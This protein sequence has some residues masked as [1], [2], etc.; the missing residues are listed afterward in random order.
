MAVE[1][2]EHHDLPGASPMSGASVARVC[3]SDELTVGSGQDRGRGHDAVIAERPQPGQLALDPRAGVIARPVHPQDAAGAGRGIV[4][5]ERGV[6]RDSQR[7]EHGIARD[8]IVPQSG[9]GDFVEAG[10]YRIR[11]Q[12]GACSGGHGATLAGRPRFHGS[13]PCPVTQ[14]TGTG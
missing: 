7:C 12:L 1:E 5:P 13:H 2:F 11:G 3:D 9:L 10:P 4:H 6:L 8:G 14:R